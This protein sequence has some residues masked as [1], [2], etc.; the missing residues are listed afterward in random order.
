MQRA[1]RFN[2]Y[3]AYFQRE[4]PT[5]SVIVTALYSDSPSNNTPY[6]L[7]LHSS[8]MSHPHRPS[9]K[10]LCF[11]RPLPR[12]SQRHPNA[13]PCQ[14]DQLYGVLFALVKKYDDCHIAPVGSAI[15][16]TMQDMAQAIFL[17]V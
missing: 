3:W 1:V 5:L 11:P 7:V 4:V 8:G 2:L 12:I 16:S 14:D 15:F 13:R 6:P 17:G 10:Q 9:H